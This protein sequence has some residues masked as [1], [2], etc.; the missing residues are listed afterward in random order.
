MEARSVLPGRGSL[1]ASPV[2]VRGRPSHTTRQ[3]PTVTPIRPSIA[4]D[5]Q[6]P[7]PARLHSVF[8]GG[9]D[10][11]KS[12]QA[13]SEALSRSTIGPALTEYGRVRRVRT[14]HA[15]SDRPPTVGHPPATTTTATRTEREFGGCRPP[16]P[17]IA[18]A[19]I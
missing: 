6:Q 7:S 14:A 9:K 18:R 4:I 15:P 17:V 16:L 19:G 10:H 8:L 1:A 13:L 3:E 2:A 11:Y 5:P 12:D